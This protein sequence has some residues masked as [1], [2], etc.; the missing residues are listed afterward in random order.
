MVLQLD[1]NRKTIFCSDAIQ[2][3]GATLVMPGAQRDGKA[4]RIFGASTTST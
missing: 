3:N 1:N 4:C 2:S